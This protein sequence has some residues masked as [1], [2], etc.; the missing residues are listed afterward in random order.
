MKK[1]MLVLEE[2]WDVCGGYVFVFR[3]RDQCQR[4]RGRVTT[5]HSCR[6][7]ELPLIR[8]RVGCSL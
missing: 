7:S 3:I 4:L 6:D 1:A 5:A 2:A 8:P